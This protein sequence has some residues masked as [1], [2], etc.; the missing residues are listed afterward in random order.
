MRLSALAGRL[1]P[2]GWVDLIRQLALFGGAYWLYRLV[3]GLVDGRAADAFDNAR[4][5]IGIERS[6]DLFFEP[7]VHHWASSQVWLQDAASWMYV[8]SH[9]AVTTLTLA[10]LYLRRNRSFYFVRN[11]FMVAM[12]IALAL[13]LVFPTAPPRLMPEWGFGDPVAHFTG[14]T[15]R[16]SAANVLYNPYAAVPSMHV[17]FALLIAVPMARVVRRR[18]LSRLWLAY[19]AVVTFVVVATANHWW[20]DAALGAATAAVAA[21][22]AHGFF[23]RVRPAA[24]AWEPGRPIAA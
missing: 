14:V 1:L 2:Q 5:L 6:L 17:A 23:A 16:D 10:Y 7:A 22:C 8:N 9:F 4:E 19:P 11:M 12:A 18:W 24:W 13:Y 20:L 15:A 21:L 3:R